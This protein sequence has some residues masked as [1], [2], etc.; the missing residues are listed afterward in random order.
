VGRYLEIVRGS[1][2]HSGGNGGWGCVS[3][4]SPANFKNPVGFHPNG[5]NFCPI[6]SDHFWK[7]FQR[8]LAVASLITYAWGV[9]SKSVGY[10][11]YLKLENML[12]DVAPVFFTRVL[13]LRARFKSL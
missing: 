9:S 6:S 5:V 11:N 7:L 4:I 13:R 1:S 8:H 12:G 2:G 10:F 3:T